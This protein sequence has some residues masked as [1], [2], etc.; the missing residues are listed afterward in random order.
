MASKHTNRLIKEKNPYLLQHA[1]N[2][3]DWHPWGEEAFEKAR[4][5]DK[6]ILL[7]IGYAT[8]HWCH[9]MEHESFEDEEVASLMNDSFVCIKVD[10]E[11]RPD[12]DNIYM[13]ACQIM[14][15]NGGW[16]LTIFMTPDKIPFMS[17]T[18]I[19]KQS[20]FGRIGM[21]DLIPRIS[22]AWKNDREKLLSVGKQVLDA[23]EQKRDSY[24]ANQPSDKL[25][26]ETYKQFK[27]NF[28]TIHGGFGN[29]PKF[30]APHNL[31]FLLRYWKKTA[32]KDAL[33][34]V[35]KTLT[36]M[37]NGGIFDHI[38]FGFHR[39]STDNEWLVPHFEKMLYDQAMLTMAYIEAYQATGNEFYA[40]TAREILTYVMR[41]MTSP[42]GGFYSA[43]DA[44]SEGVEGKFYLW[45]YDEIKEALGEE[46]SDFAVKVFNVAKDGNFSDEMKG[47]TTGKNILHLSKSSHEFL[48]ESE[49]SSIEFD[50]RIKGCRQKLLAHRK[51]RVRPLRDDKILTDWNGLMI[52]AFA[53]VAQVL[54]E[55]GYAEAAKRSADF[56]L[57]KM[58]TK[59]GRLLHRYR[60]GEAA[61]MGMLDDYSFFVWGLLELYE[62][63][64]ETKYLRHAIDI[65]KN[66]I[67]HFRDD[68]A[69]GLFQTADDGEALISR[70]KE[71][72]DG[73][74]PSGNS[75]AL[76]NLIRL[77]RITG[78]TT[79]ETSA[80][81]LVRE[82]TIEIEYMPSV[83]TMF[84]SSLDY[85]LG[86]SYEIVIAGNPDAKDT[87]EILRT[88]RK[89]FN[90]NK[91]VILRPPYG[92][93]SDIYE[94]APF[95]KSQKSLNGK[96]TAYVC[97]NHT[98]SMPTTD[99]EE[100]K[101]KF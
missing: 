12:I 89:N 7:S 24:P 87:K 8:C 79:F 29:R 43:E 49:F 98:C 78:D 35:E 62:A 64:F 6:P 39:Y 73:A 36:A 22:H 77:A 14:T 65:S 61:I 45:T 44:D 5:E 82:F 18:Y 86:P 81:N 97:H 71:A 68:K 25:F 30:P 57:S 83:Y 101:R 1:Y 100:L 53:K 66:M 56:V 67:L 16:P 63:T 13:T 59:D 27:N 33:M 48:E 21:L 37:R 51:K 60:D 28:D 90:P 52:V 76:L 85:L 26:E 55:P 50:N 20:A 69:G 96:A 94:I 3:V 41:D 32:D 58:T 92:S 91:V 93:P 74:I 15:G 11:E 19:P 84:L 42:D 23:L 99:V 10:R 9:V 75:I 31:M 4:H 80:N 47:G 46:D 40:K 70:R 72:H 88:I 2:P 95:C 38:G 54:D 34:M 17:A